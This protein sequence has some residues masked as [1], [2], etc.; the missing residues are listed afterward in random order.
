MAD[1]GGLL[2]FSGLDEDQQRMAVA[3]GLL[4]LGSG[5]LANQ[6]YDPRTG[7]GGLTSGLAQGAQAMMAAP[8]QVRQQ[9][10]QDAV[11]KQKLLEMKRLQDEQTRKDSF[12]KSMFGDAPA[13]AGQYAQPQQASTQPSSPA[14]GG[15]AIPAS[16]QGASV[17]SPSSI[18]GMSLPPGLTRATANA[19]GPDATWS[20]ILDYNKKLT[21]KGLEAPKVE[22]AY[23]P[24]TGREVKQQ[25]NPITRQ[26]EALGGVKGPDVGTG[27]VYDARTGTT[28][29]VPGWDRAQ[30]SLA[31][32]KSGAEAGAR[33][34]ADIA[35]MP[36]KAAA[37]AKLIAVPTADGKTV[38]MPVGGVS[39]YTQGVGKAVAPNNNSF[40]D[41][42]TLRD[43]WTAATKDYRTLTDAYRKMKLASQGDS[44]A[45]DMSLVFGLMKMNDPGS[46]VR[47]GEYATAENARGVG[48][49]MMNIYNKVLTGQRLTPSQREDFM[50]QAANMHKAQT[51]GYTALKK[52]Y[53]ER[54]KRRGLNVDDVIT[55]YG[56]VDYGQQAATPQQPVAAPVQ[57]KDDFDYAKL[58]P[59]SVFIGPDGKQRRKP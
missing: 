20:L 11:M 17:A 12:F 3:N 19:L 36:K 15:S 52:D 16:S 43:E 26:W 42:N 24:A 4:G 51:E 21:E 59:G 28:S 18:N 50:T 48:E 23:D 56:D 47:E 6:Y 27:M 13:Q 31:G 7:Q 9:A 58:A 30:V 40:G 57:I 44:A 54:A 22:T 5:L 55:N 53:T 45:S 32:A 39:D 33:N 29:F 46:T 2:G 14:V 1:M 49:G 8:A 35:A 10:Y 38:M 25:Y 37:A 34:A 41:A